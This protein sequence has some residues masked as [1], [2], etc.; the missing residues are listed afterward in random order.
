MGILPV[1]TT[2]QF[3]VLF[4]ALY[5]YYNYSQDQTIS[6]SQN[7]LCGSCEIEVGVCTQRRFIQ[8]LFGDVALPTAPAAGL[9]Y[10]RMTCE[11]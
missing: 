10:I 2:L 6:K 7:T 4:I 9:A 5:F 3:A 1:T 8:Y 11:D